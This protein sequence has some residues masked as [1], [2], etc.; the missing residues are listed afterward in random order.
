MMLDLGTVAVEI[1]SIKKIF[2]FNEV[3]GLFNKIT[4][5]ELGLTF[6]NDY[7]LESWSNTSCYTY[8]TEAERD[9][10]YQLIINTINSQGN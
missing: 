7:S 4:L 1:K 10:Y 8:E 3:R 9:K 6:Y 2:K 5:F